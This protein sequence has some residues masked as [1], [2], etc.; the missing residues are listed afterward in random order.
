[1]GCLSYRANLCGEGVLLGVMEDVTLCK[2]E[3]SHAGVSPCGAW[4]IM[5][6]G[7]H[8]SSRTHDCVLCARL[9]WESLPAL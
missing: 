8:K 5:P 2:W 9:Y 1:M 7:C 4:G 3:W 6:A